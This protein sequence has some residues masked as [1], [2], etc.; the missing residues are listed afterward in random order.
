MP[1]N[2]Y[3]ILG[4]PA[5]SSQDDIKAAYRRLAK[6]YHPDYYGPNKGP[7]QI[8]QEAYSILSDPKRR[9]SYDQ[10][11]LDHVPRSDKQ[12][13]QSSAFSAP[14]EPLIPEK[15]RKYP[16][17]RTDLTRH[18]FRSI[19]DTIFDQQ[20]DNV[21]EPSLSPWK[22]LRS[23]TVEIELTP[24]QARTGGNVE[25]HIPVELRCPSCY[26]RLASYHYPCW[27]C[28]GSGK[29]KGEKPLLVSYPAGI[30]ERHATTFCT[31][32]SNGVQLYLTIV[33]RILPYW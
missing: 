30:Q 25:L 29:I 14:I 16:P 21:H 9:R 7:F 32:I 31:T 27:R 6:E 23:E 28:N 15:E 12:P 2:Y 4:I 17:P 5:N 11:T 3:I 1:K 33:F 24:E 22:Q 8:I 26:N 18:S 10:A 13:K 20:L 19:F